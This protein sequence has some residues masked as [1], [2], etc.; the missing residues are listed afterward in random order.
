MAAH[1]DWTA[2]AMIFSGRPDPEWPLPADAVETLL[3]LWQE[4]KPRGRVPAP[5][6]VLGYRGCWIRDPHGVCWR[7]FDG[8]VVREAPRR[9]ASETRRDEKRAFERA[10]LATAPAGTLPPGVGP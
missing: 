1:A 9:G 10:V 3:A 4:L 8:V 2:G 6:A 7:A 5:R